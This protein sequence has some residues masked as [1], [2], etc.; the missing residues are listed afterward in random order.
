MTQTRVRKPYKCLK[1]VTPAGTVEWDVVTRRLELPVGKVW[2]S[3]SWWLMARWSSED[4]AYKMPATR[5][6]SLGD[7]AQAAYDQRKEPL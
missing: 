3:F 1:V 2:R 7:A 4:Q 6:D 5:Y